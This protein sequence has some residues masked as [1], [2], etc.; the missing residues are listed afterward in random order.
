MTRSPDSRTRRRER[1]RKVLIGLLLVSAIGAVAYLN[2]RKRKPA[3]T[4]ASVAVERTDLVDK[5]AETGSI[6][7]VRTVEVKSTIAGEVRHLGVEAGEWVEAEQLMAV[8]EPD[9]NQSL[10][11]YQKRSAVERGKINLDEQVREF[12]RKKALFQ[13]HML[14]A[15]EFEAAQVRLTRARHDLQL[16]KL[17]LAILETKANLAPQDLGESQDLDEVRVLA[18]ISGIV[19]QRGVEIGE[20][21]ASGLNSYTGGTVLFV[22]GDPSQ[23]IVRGDVAEVDIAGLEEG[24]EVEIVVDAYPDTT[25]QGKVRWMAPVA[26]R[27]QNSPI[28]TFDTEI[29]ILDN[30]PR[31][32]QG[33]SCDIDI[34]F[35]HRDSTLCLPVETVLK[36]EPEGEEGQR[37]DSRYIVYRVLPDSIRTSSRVGD[38]PPGAT[39]MG[40]AGAMVA[41][42]AAW[43]TDSAAAADTGRAGNRAGSD[44]C[45]ESSGAG[46]GANSTH[47][48]TAADSVEADS[49][50]ASRTSAGPDS[51]GTA[52]TTDHRQAA[53][54]A[55]AAT[56]DSVPSDS[57]SAEPQQASEPPRFELDRFKKVQVEIGLESATH[58]EILSG[59]QD[60]DRV[61]A[62]P[63][64]IRR[65]KAEAAEKQAANG[66]KGL[67]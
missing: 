33:M 62:D 66:K 3:E 7:L 49:P 15:Q 24:Q 2:L 27:K 37:R 30:E 55:V 31:L 26:E 28:V 51:A 5:L 20:V 45:S 56:P 50:V 29:D 8:I 60:G 34:I 10:Q 18:P 32:R 22:I 4:F 64:T 36:V 21:V 41:F 57:A 67:F 13:S 1:R 39:T 63:E 48:G 61:A 43:G 23:M 46:A 47:H 6:E 65:M 38:A 14:P 59:L 44:S 12:E 9:P 53:D 17:E 42:R 16:A 52:G 58:V 35:D 25:Y 19:I 54:T 40:V 11:L